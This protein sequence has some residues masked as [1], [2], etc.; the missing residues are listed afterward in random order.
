MI[1]FAWVRATSAWMRAISA[2][3]RAIFTRV[4]AISAWVRAISNI[5]WTYQW[6]YRYL[7]KDSCKINKKRGNF[8]F[9]C[10]YYILLVIMYYSIIL[11]CILLY[12]ILLLKRSNIACNWITHD[13]YLSLFL[14][15]KEHFS[16]VKNNR[17]RE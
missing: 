9:L 5:N 11:T 7:E 6:M 17:I 2:W 10:S 3:M 1:I 13:F 12:S 8:F 4:R 14:A 16:I 15:K